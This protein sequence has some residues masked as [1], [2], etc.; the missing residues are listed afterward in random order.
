MAV[1][2]YLRRILESLDHPDM[3]N[4]ILH[5]LLAL[6]ETAAS[7]ESTS[8]SSVGDARRRKSLDLA[9]MMAERL[10]DTATP[11]LFNLVDLIL[12]CLRSRNQQTIHVTLQLVSAI[13]KRHH[14]YAVITLL[15][16]E[17]GP[18][19]AGHRTVGAHE[20]EVEHMVALASSIGGHG[21]FDDMYGNIL[22]D[23]MARLESHPCSLRLVAPRLP[24]GNSK[25]PAVPDSLPGAPRDVH[26][27]SLRADDPLLNATLDL[28]ETFFT[29]P[30]EMNLSV[31]ETMVDLATCG[32][33]NIEGWLARSPE[34]YSF[35]EQ[36]GEAA[37]QVA[38]SL[39]GHQDELET[40]PSRPSWDKGLSV[41]EA[42]RLQALAK[43]RRRPEWREES[44]PRML[45][46]LKR[47]RDQV[48]SFKDTIPRFEELLQQRREAFQTA[49]TMLDQPPPARKESSASQSTPERP[50]PDRTA[51]A[52][53]PSR[54][55][56]L[57]GLAQRFLQELGTPSRSVSPRG[58]KEP[59]RGHGSSTP[60]TTPGL[61][62]SSIP[63]A[64]R[65]APNAN[66][67]DPH[68]SGTTL[69]SSPSGSRGDTAS[70]VGMASAASQAAAFA[71][72]DQSILARRVGL[73]DDK[74]KTIPIRWDTKPSEEE[75]AS[76][77][78]GDTA[79]T[80][81][82]ET[83]ADAQADTR[84]EETKVSVSH[85]VTNVIIFQS[86]LLE[87]AGLMQ[88]RV[89]LFGEVRSV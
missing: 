3:I 83:A 57:E 75:A 88:V 61:S 31:T 56:A 69:N 26:Q 70:S 25:L 68:R 76:G 24:T 45:R 63:R 53:S 85:I 23:T 32:Y 42:Q 47:L 8:K 89:G 15:K 41:D 4:L 34:T 71:A 74:L 22:K 43:C 52:G 1:L 84:A 86:F 7:P 21:D 13:L 36:E 46:L 62:E 67:A 87:L 27:H 2:T 59:G 66:H 54:P 79:R 9:T 51:R 29:N 6:P 37:D 44:V 39:E 82:T 20:Q 60:S 30:V 78:V 80:P 10:P 5:Y 48:S 14:R 65:V 38:T 64:A 18:G 55:S 77:D 35:N 72:I 12:A 17:V 50:S 58:R 16:T 28:V 73:P 81:A 19:N 49:E 33:M 40:P 11:L